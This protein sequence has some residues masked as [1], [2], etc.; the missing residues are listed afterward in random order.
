MLHTG[1]KIGLYFC[2]FMNHEHSNR[3]KVD[4]MLIKG[5]MSD[6]DANNKQ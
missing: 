4:V 1:S 6:S 2:E 5:G 3:V